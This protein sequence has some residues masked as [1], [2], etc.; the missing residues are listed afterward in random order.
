VIFRRDRRDP[1]EAANAR[2]WAWWAKARERDLADPVLIKQMHQQVSAISPALEWEFGPGTAACHLLVVSAGGDSSL[3]SVTERWRRSGPA[4]DETFEY[5]AARRPDPAALLGELDIAGQQ[6][7]LSALRFTG[8]PDPSTR[9]VDVEMWHP[10][11]VSMTAVHRSRVKFLALDWLLGEDTV[12]IW[13]GRIAVTTEPGPAL[14][15]TELAAVVASQIPPD[16]KLPWRNVA[17]TRAGRAL[18]AAAQ[19]PLRAASHPAH[20]LH[21]RVDVPYTDRIGN[22]LP[23]RPALDELYALE[24]RLYQH[25][26]GA[27]LVAHEMSDGLWTDHFYAD[28]QAA[29]EALRPLVTAWPHGPVRITTTPD[30]KWSAVAHL[31]R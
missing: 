3:R 14:T 6:I 12:E 5:A 28:R 4:N 22:G 20:D 31:A 10:A 16:G 15:A 13:L 21:V 25:A 2:F 27:V 19:A 11:F 30:A 7:D 18:M 1:V 23:T 8:R 9:V 24:D 29:A 26:D 17:G